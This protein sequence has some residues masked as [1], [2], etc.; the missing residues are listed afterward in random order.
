M[1]TN[2]LQSISTQLNAGHSNDA[3]SLWLFADR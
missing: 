2:V 1:F 3:P